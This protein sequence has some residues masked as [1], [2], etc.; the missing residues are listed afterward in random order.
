ML[1][2][3]WDSS[4]LTCLFVVCVVE[5][6]TL[7]RSEDKTQIK[8]LPGPEVDSLIADYYKEEERKKEEKAAQ[9]KKPTTSST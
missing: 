4:V 7:K 6:A 1:T 3:L 2:L 9:E 5:I 8:V